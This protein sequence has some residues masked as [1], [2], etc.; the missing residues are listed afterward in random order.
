MLHTLH[1]SPFNTDINSL[2][3]M[4]GPDDTLLL[5]QDGVIAALQ[6]NPYLELLRASQAEVCV[7]QEDVA[8]RGL[9]GQISSDI[10]LIGYTD[11]V[12]LALKHTNQM[13][14]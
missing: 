5:I 2:L 1:L 10:P 4:L 8:A 3:R 6:G 14:W 13:A 9:S 11:F 7:L 12:N